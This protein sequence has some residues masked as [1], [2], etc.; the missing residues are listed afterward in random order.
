MCVCVDIR[1]V[2]WVIQY[3]TPEIKYGRGGY[4]SCARR[5]HTRRK[6]SL[7]SSRAFSKS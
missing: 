5:S 1:Y 6:T 2:L 4:F 3:R 7:T